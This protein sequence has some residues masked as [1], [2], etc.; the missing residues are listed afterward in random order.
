MSHPESQSSK[1]C[2]R[3]VIPVRYYETDQMGVVHHAIYIH[4]FEVG[5]TELMESHGLDYAEMERRGTLLAVVE[6]AVRHLGPARYGQR[7]VVETDLTRV[8]KVRIRFDYR[9]L[10]AGESEQL[11]C[12]GHTVLACVNRDLKPQRLPREDRERMLALVSKNGTNPSP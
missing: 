9:V 7:V 6:V 2:H 1:P 5:R 11:L 12:Q 3:T 4:W 8:E 10:L